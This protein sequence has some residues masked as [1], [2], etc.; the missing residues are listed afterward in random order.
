MLTLDLEN[1]R[2]LKEWKQICGIQS[3]C[4]FVN[5]GFG[6]W[7]NETWKPF[8]EGKIFS[9]AMSSKERKNKTKK[10]QKQIE[11]ELDCTYKILKGQSSIKVL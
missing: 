2:S 7:T 11:G 9:L 10:T 6:R 4:N 5:D 1:M 3:T 8:S